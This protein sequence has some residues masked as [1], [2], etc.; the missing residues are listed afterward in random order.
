MGRWR[1]TGGKANDDDQRRPRSLGA[2][3]CYHNP[4]DKRLR[5]AKR[6]TA[7]E[8]KVPAVLPAPAPAAEA[9]A[10]AEAGAVAQTE[11][12]VGAASSCS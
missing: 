3:L 1:G 9:E 7:R 5:K 2:L 8:Q 10:E 12:A 6:E 11:A 4:Q